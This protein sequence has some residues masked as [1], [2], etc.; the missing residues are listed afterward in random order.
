MNFLDRAIEDYH[1]ILRKHEDEV[2]A[3]Y[4]AF[5][6]ELISRKLTYGG[7][8]MT[9]YLR[10]QFVTNSQVQMLASMCAVLRRAITKAKDILLEDKE[11]FEELGL[12]DGE[13]MLV[14]INPM[15][16]PI[17]VT[18]R[19]DSF[20]Y[21]DSV[22]FVELNAEVPAGPAYCDKTTNFFL[23]YPPIKEFLKKYKVHTFAVT[24][25]LADALLQAWRLF[26]GTG[27]PRVAVVDWQ[28]VS[29]RNEFDLVADIFNARGIPTFFADPREL[30]FDGNFL[31]HRGKKIDLVYRRVLTNEFL[32]K[33]DEVRPMLDAYR[34]HKV[35]VVNSFR[36]KLLHKKIIFGVLHDPRLDKHYTDDERH[37]VRAC[38]PWTARVHEGKVMRDGKLIDLVPYMMENKDNLVI[39]PNDDYGG[40]GVNL[41]WHLDRGDWER[42]IKVAMVDP[43]VVQEKVAVPDAPFPEVRDGRLAFPNAYIDLDPYLFYGDFGGILTRLSI[44]QKCNVTAGGGMVPTFVIDDSQAIA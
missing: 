2:V 14:D 44:S 13:R 16:E 36:S 6:E 17:G 3:W 28:E 23:A 1:D 7:R 35:L 37:V 24:Q 32:A 19:L 9:P 11:L 25:R 42:A 5:V 30:E 21:H 33:L 15:L 22:R 39:K 31:S 41:G 20:L 10:P 40:R 27:I 12:T 4:P 26:G 43:S 29:T 34:A 18:T 38:I 8:I